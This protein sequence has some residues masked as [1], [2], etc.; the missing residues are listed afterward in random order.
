MVLWGDVHQHAEC[1]QQQ[2]LNQASCTRCEA[3]GPG[4]E[5]VAADAAQKRSK[6]YQHDGQ[7]VQVGSIIISLMNEST[8]VQRDGVVL[9]GV[10]VGK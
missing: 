4:N 3:Q 9:G 1:V 10:G 8:M 6:L 2:F 7:E 5:F